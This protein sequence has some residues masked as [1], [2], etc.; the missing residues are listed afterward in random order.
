MADELFGQLDLR[1]ME[2][3]YR[4]MDRDVAYPLRELECDEEEL[5][6]SLESEFT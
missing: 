6:E 2:L 5:W 4:R 1:E 3:E